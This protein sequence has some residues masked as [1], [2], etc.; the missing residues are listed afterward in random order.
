MTQNQVAYKTSVP[1]LDDGVLASEFPWLADFASLDEA[2]VDSWRYRYVKRSLDLF[3]ALI[4][5]AVFAIPGLLIAALI[6]AT[7]RGPV[8][9]REQRIGRNGRFFRVWKFRSMYRDADQRA[10]IAEQQPGAKVLE[11]RMHKHLRDPRVT[12]VGRVLRQWSL[13]ELPQLINVLRG[14][15]SLIGPRPIVQAEIENYGS[16]FSHYL[17]ATPGLS[18]LWQVSG[19]CHIDYEQRAEMDAAYVNSWSLKADAG[20]LFRTVPAVLSRIGAN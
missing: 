19:R 4:M 13:D 1:S 14:D 18:G 6:L 15:M 11:W 9:Y 10:L 20:I 2:P 7:S 5:F 8:F 12:V 16:L 17:A 3:C